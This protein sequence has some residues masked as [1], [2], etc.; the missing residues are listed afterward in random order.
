MTVPQ[1]VDLTVCIAYFNGRQTIQRALESLVSAR[2]APAR[3]V[4]TSDA[5]PDHPGAFLRSLAEGVPFPCEVRENSHNCGVAAT[6]N[7]M[8]RASSTEWT[9]ILDQ[10]DCYVRGGF[11]RICEHVTT[12]QRHDVIAAAM[13]SNVRFLD[14]AARVTSLA[15]RPFRVPRQIPVRGSF[16]TGS[17]IIYRTSVLRSFPF[18]DPAVDGS[19]VVHLDSIRA[20]HP[21]LLIPRAGVH[22]E[23]HQG[24][25]SSAA[26][27]GV[28][29]S[30][31]LYAADYFLRRRL[32]RA[33]MT[34]RNRNR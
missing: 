16:V 34:R 10:D 4:I 14:V 6:Y 32:A 3:V 19:D 21:M 25:F 27:G 7:R 26:D 13:R 29:P 9:Q 22:Y 17:G 2:F 15:P 28:R 12:S 24:A 20:R 11:E 23:V 5:S 31:A 1:T 30:G 33:F 8:I 18:P